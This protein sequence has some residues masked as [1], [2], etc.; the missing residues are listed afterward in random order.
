MDRENSYKYVTLM[1]CWLG[2]F[3]NWLSRGIIPVVLPS[4]SQEF[5]LA[6]KEASLLSA[7]LF[8][9]YAGCQIPSG[10]VADRYGRKVTMVLCT[11]SYSGAMLL[12]GLTAS[13]Y[14]HL[15]LFHSLIGVGTAFYFVPAI[16]IISDSFPRGKL[17]KA[18]GIYFTAPSLGMIAA[19]L[20]AAPLTENFGWI[21]PYFVC[22]FLGFI[23][24]SMI[25]LAAKEPHQREKKAFEGRLPSILDVFTD[26]NINKIAVI[27]FMTAQVMGLFSL[28]PLYLVNEQ[29]TTLSFAGLV[30]AVLQLGS[31]IGS[32][33]G[34]VLS[35]R[36]SRKAII[37]AML[38]ASTAIYLF[39]FFSEFSYSVFLLVF[40]RLFHIAITPSMSAYITETTHQSER[41]KVFS[42][43]NT[44]TILGIATAS[45]TIGAIA[46]TFGFVSSFIFLAIVYSFGSVI[47]LSLKKID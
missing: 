31:L 11:L 28:I 30:F 47:A 19:P 14:G 8:F 33:L 22:A 21:A 10:L 27:N 43:T 9:A 44:I 4:I 24:A 36:F 40:A 35:D 2:F 45:I 41:G 13:T 7:I 17:G 18:L 38:L 26:K 39:E 34:G 16:D 32:P 6:Y 12:T 37:I 3:S 1:I 20:I 29:H 23:L 46:D 25:Q 5:G 15:L 42:Y